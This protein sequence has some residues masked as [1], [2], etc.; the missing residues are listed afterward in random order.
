[1]ILKKLVSVCLGICCILVSF[2]TVYATGKVFSIN[3]D[4]VTSAMGDAGVALPSTSVNG[5]V[6]NPSATIG[7]YRTVASISATNLT[8]DILHTYGGIGFL[9]PIGVFGAS[10]MYVDYQSIILLFGR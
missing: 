5:A 3:P 7:I 2:N 9:S 8:G 1:M 4:P 10:L 6:I